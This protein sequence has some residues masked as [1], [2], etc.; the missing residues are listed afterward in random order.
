MITSQGAIYTT[1]NGGLNWKA[2][3]KETID[4]TLNRV[5]SSGTSGAS[6]FTG[7]LINQIRDINGN[8]LAVGSRGNLF[9]TW[10]RGDE[11]W[12]PHNRGSSRRIQNMGFIQNDASKGV[13][14]TLNGGS[15]LV[16]ISLN[17]V[18]TV[19]IKAAFGSTERIMIQKRG[20]HTCT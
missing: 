3:V 16:G 7:R 17:N 6:Y 12:V 14:M 2:Q 10:T 18:I 9:L 13:W 15:L 1:V 5:S 20:V 8:Y 19:I 11:Y 4:A